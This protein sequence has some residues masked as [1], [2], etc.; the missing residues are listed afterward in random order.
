VKKT[1]ET[2]T[3]ADRS[4]YIC[5]VCNRDVG[6]SSA[7]VPLTVDDGRPPGT[8]NRWRTAGYAC[9]HHESRAY[10]ILKGEVIER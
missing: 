6:F 1:D 3:T 8:P 7:Y 5:P 4:L 2:A 9:E 10:E